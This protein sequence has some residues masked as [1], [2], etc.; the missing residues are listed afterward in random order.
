MLRAPFGNRPYGP[1]TG[2]RNAPTNPAFRDWNARPATRPGG[3]R[4]RYAPFRRSSKPGRGRR[5]TGY[6]PRS[7]SYRGSASQS[8]RSCLL[9]SHPEK[10]FLD[11]IM[12]RNPGVAG[13]P[14][15]LAIIPQGVTESERVGRKVI[16]TDI[17]LKGH[18][19][20]DTVGNKTGTGRVRIVICQ[21]KQTNGVLALNSTYF[22]PTDINGYRDLN[23]SPKFVTLFDKTYESNPQTGAGDGTLNDMAQMWVPVNISIKCCIPILYD[24]SVDTGAI[25]SQTV[26][27]IVAF[28][29]EEA[30][31]PASTV[32]LH[33]RIRYVE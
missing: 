5:S 9:G 33:S 18:I 20:F 30:T 17:L 4:G 19:Q 16:V 28:F 27:S 7:G 24:D 2:H 25:T 12:D 32:H 29:Q 11:E 31:T 13:A 3:G 21:N 15:A 10:K 6:G 22:S 1:S 26:N 23:N 14:H 8:R